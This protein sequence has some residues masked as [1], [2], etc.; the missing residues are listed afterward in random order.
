MHFASKFVDECS[1]TDACEQLF[2][3]LHSR[4]NGC[5]P[6]AV[7]GYTGS[8]KET[9]AYTAATKVTSK[10]VRAVDMDNMCDKP[11][12]AVALDANGSVVAHMSLVPPA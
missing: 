5:G 3:Q 6:F 11:V 4:M 7:T 12:V 8:Y 1:S 2:L 10:A 9:G